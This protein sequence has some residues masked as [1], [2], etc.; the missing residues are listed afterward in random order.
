[1][2]ADGSVHLLVPFEDHVTT[3]PVFSGGVQVGQ[4]NK[5]SYT[6]PLYKAFSPGRRQ[7]AVA[8]LVTSGFFESQQVPN[9]DVLTG[10]SQTPVLNIYS[11]G[12]EGTGAQLVVLGR[13]R[14][15]Y[16]LGGFGVDWHPTQNL[17][18]APIDVDAPTVGTT[19]PSESS[20]LFLI[21]AVPNAVA[22]G[23]GRQL[24][25]PQ[26]FLRSSLFSTTASLQTDYAPAF[27]PDGE[28]VAYLRA[29][30]TIDSNG[31]VTQHRP[32]V[33]SIRAVGTDGANDHLILSLNAGLFVTQLTWSPDGRQLVFDSGNQPAPQPNQLARLEAVP[34]TLQLSIVNR[35]GSNPHLLRGP[36]A[37]MPAWQPS[38]ATPTAPPLQLQLIPGTPRT[39]LLSWPTV[40]D[41]LT[42]E[43]TGALGAQ[44]NWTALPL[45]VTSANGLSSATL[46]LDAPFGFF[47]IRAP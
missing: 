40:P 24:T 31:F 4:Q 1:V 6:V 33:V 3:E 13:V 18:V 11:G 38:V 26:G 39:L 17:L 14:T 45:Q 34:G 32:I 42:V 35:D 41:P 20:A 19:T 44:A 23:K 30:N 27:S 2:P 29:E 25:H 10:T 7:L 21:E 37:G 28:T 15:F 47:R 8:S 46:S 5:F 43:L 9:P 12:T 22:L 16:T 36:S